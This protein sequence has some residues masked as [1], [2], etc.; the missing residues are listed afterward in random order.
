M[1]RSIYLAGSFVPLCL[2]FF[3]AASAAQNDDA[4]APKPPTCPA[5]AK[6]KAVER[7]KNPDGTAL[8]TRYCGRARFVAKV[9]A[10]TI[11]VRGF[12]GHIYPNE[13]V[14]VGDN[15][16]SVRWLN[17]GLSTDWRTTPV[18]YGLGLVLNGT[19][20]RQEGVLKVD[21]GE[22]QMPGVSGA[23][24]GTAIA[25]GTSWQR[26][27]FAVKLR[28]ASPESFNGTIITG[29]WTCQKEKPP[30]FGPWPPK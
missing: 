16:S 29:S 25:E 1:R 26:G 21:D 6:P 19:V 27:H 23:L 8:F 2:V 24:D 3:A 9:G 14:S 30:G 10:K 18:G 13:Y 7:G 28:G 22:F 15:T 17:G 4:T 20:S 11:R 5:S 12:C